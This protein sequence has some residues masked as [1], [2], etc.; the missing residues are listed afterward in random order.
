MKKYVVKNGRF[1]VVLVAS[2]FLLILAGF[3][4][5][6]PFKIPKEVK[7]VVGTLDINAVTGTAWTP[8][9]IW[10]SSGN[11]GIGTTAPG[12]KLDIS[13][14]QLR[15]TEGTANRYAILY[16]DGLRFTRSSDGSDTGRIDYDGVD[17]ITYNSAGGG[18]GVRHLWQVN[19][20]DVMAIDNSG[21]VGIGTTG[22]AYPLDVTGNVRSSGHLGLSG[23]NPSSHWSIY[24]D[25]T[26]TN[27]NSVGGIQTLARVYTTGA[28]ASHT[29]YGSLTYGIAYPA[30]T[31]SNTG[32]MHGIYSISGNWDVGTLS[33]ATGVYGVA[34]NNTTG[35]ITTA[36]GLKSYINN[37]STGTIT[38][39]YGVHIADVD[40]TTGYGLYQVGANDINYFAG[41]VGIGT[42]APGAYKL[43]VNGNT[44]ITGTL[45]T[46][47][48]INGQTISSAA[49]FTGTMAI[50]GDLALNGIYDALNF[51]SGWATI[52]YTDGNGR[53]SI[54]EN[55]TGGVSSIYTNSEAANRMTM[56]TTGI[57]FYNAASGTAGNAITWSQTGNINQ[58]SV[59]F[60]PRGTSSD[61]YVNSSGNVGI[62]TTAP[63]YKLEVAGVVYASGSSRDYKQ[64]I[65][66]LEVDSSKI[67]DLQPVSYDYKKEY[68]DLGYTLAGGRQFGL[69]AE[70]TFKVIPELVISKNDKKTANI[71]YEKLSVLLLSE[72]KKLKNTV[73]Q[74]QKQINQLQTIIGITKP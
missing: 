63:N 7:A 67:Y 1:P 27:T 6:K 4:Y 25:E 64:D 10:N 59:W 38:R 61:F 48:L 58:T 28:T 41:N 29:G 66:N 45:T 35:I 11:V 44:N 26:Y 9:G 2:F 40:A 72:M 71:D 69:I 31:F 70:D 8:G 52:G 43:N 62:G 20:S 3:L 51:G 21:Y 36:Y 18:T 73:D 53:F 55:A 68:K 42:T 50:A 49:N 37:V 54:Y 74:Q 12:K 39:G 34:Q 14:G 65:K 57:N 24:A 46:S 23:S 60:S 30:S 32:A 5:S 19:S 22:P 17:Q 47:G 15:L 56:S 13:G 16:E 33:A